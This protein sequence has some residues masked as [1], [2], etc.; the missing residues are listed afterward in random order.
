M[1][2]INTNERRTDELMVALE[3]GVFVVTRKREYETDKVVGVATTL[4]GAAVL[5]IDDADFWV[6]E[7]PVTSMNREVWSKYFRWLDDN[8]GILAHSFRRSVGEMTATWGNEH[9]G[10]DD[11]GYRVQW[12]GLATAV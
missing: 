11:Y 10:Y 1:T 4:D 7:N 8:R 5:V 2:G 12:T 3:V 9:D 6:E